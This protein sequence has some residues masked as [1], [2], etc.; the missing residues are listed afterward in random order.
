V[1]KSAA[2]DFRVEIRGHTDSKG[3]ADY[4]QKLSERRA[5]AVRDYFISK[6]VPASQM[7]TKGYGST[8]PIADNATEEGRAVNRRIEP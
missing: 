2:P 6:G 3:A 4:N 8:K 1:S 7:T 5:E